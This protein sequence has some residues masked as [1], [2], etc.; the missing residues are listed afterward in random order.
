M[1]ITPIITMSDKKI[2][3][4]Y[5][6][7]DSNYKNNLAGED[8][9][10]GEWIVD[11]HRIKSI[12]FGVKKPEMQFRGNFHVNLTGISQFGIFV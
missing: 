7:F 10:N 2:K 4:I 9:K 12:S 8:L 3:K 11:T 6:V 1:A 5:E